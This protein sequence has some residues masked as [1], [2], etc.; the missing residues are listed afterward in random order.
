VCLCDEIQI[1]H[2]WRNT[3]ETCVLR[4]SPWEAHGVPH[5][6]PDADNGSKVVSTIELVLFRLM[7][8]KS[9]YRGRT[10]LSLVFLFSLPTWVYGFQFYSVGYY[11]SLSKFILKF[12]FLPAWLATALWDLYSTVGKLSLSIV[13]VTLSEL[14]LH[15]V[16]T[17][18]APQV[19]SVVWDTFGRLGKAART[20]RVDWD[21]QGSQW[22]R[23][24]EKF[25]KAEWYSVLCISVVCT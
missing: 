11:A 14:G 22:T 12:S 13:E 5:T 16:Q 1:L 9:L 6:C 2:F 4:T 25:R 19:H 10:F 20:A 3:A 7:G 8:A 23:R 21:A 17:S 15:G 18:L 24:E